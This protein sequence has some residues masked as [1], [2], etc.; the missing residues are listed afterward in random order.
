M[1]SESPVSLEAVRS[2]VRGL[3][4]PL[5]AQLKMVESRER[6]ILNDLQATREI[7]AELISTLRKLDPDMPRP[8]KKKKGAAT[9]NGRGLPSNEVMEVVRKAVDEVAVKYPDGFTR[10][11]VGEQ[12]KEDGV[13][14]G[15]ARQKAAIEELHN[16][17]YLTLH[18]LVTGGNK[19]FKRTEDLNGSARHAV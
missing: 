6:F 4:E 19:S 10:A 16:S 17:G 3:I 14:M 13:P 1:V 2:E 12:L 15:D 8:G 18:K 9:S 5:K 7:K 11:R